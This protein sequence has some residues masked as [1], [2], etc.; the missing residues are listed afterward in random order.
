MIFI[1]FGAR[2]SSYSQNSE[3]LKGHKI[4]QK[5]YNSDKTDTNDKQF[6]N[7]VGT[8]VTGFL[9]CVWVYELLLRP[10]RVRNTQTGTG[11]KHATLRTSRND[12][13]LC[14]EGPALDESWKHRSQ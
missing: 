8:D 5:L 2:K 7:K 12:E 3:I 10:S 14:K 1:Y 9:Q 4:T 13:G 11:Y 6:K